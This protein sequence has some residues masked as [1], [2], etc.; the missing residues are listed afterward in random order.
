MFSHLFSWTPVPYAYLTLYHTVLIASL[1][2]RPCPQRRLFFLPLLALTWQLLHDAQAG[3]ITSMY[4]FTSL[5]MASD[6]ILLTDVQRELRQVHDS[7]DRR[8]SQPIQNIEDAPFLER[9]N[10]AVHLFFNA[11]GVGWAH[12][13]RNALP[14]RAPPNTPRIRFIVEQ[15]LRLG[16]TLVLF[17]LVNLHVRWNPALGLR[18]GLAF[19]GWTWRVIGTV[20]WAAGAF[21]GL[22]SV[23][24]TSSIVCVSG[25]LFRKIGL[26]SLV[27]SQMQRACGPSGRKRGWHQLLR[28]SLCA[29]GQFVSGTLMRLSPGS[30]ASSCV[31]LVVAFLL[32]GLVHSLGETPPLGLER[33]GSLIFFGIQPAGIAC[34]M[35]AARLSRRVGLSLPRSAS[36]VLGCAWVL[37]WF[38]LTLPIM[39]DPLIRAGELDSRVNVSLFMRAWKGTWF[40]PPIGSA[41]FTSERF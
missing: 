17:D 27:G 28:R 8:A 18:L 26:R 4:W 33:S 39:Q 2:T 16:A 7:S 24:Y 32:S 35:L 31:Q 41:A 9:V 29:H 34:E 1:A 13:P 3:Y 11:R 36:K 30:T 10:W 37:A 6:Y 22:A 21:A 23:H 5:V 15:T 20:G 38:T 25:Y 19:V 40:L 14:S 12:E